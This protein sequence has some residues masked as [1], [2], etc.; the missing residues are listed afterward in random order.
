MLPR[1]GSIVK[2]IFDL[3][4]GRTQD[5]NLCTAKIGG[6]HGVKSTCNGNL[7]ALL[8]KMATITF[9][10]GNAKKLGEVNAIMA[11]GNPVLCS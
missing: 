9:V 4:V 2:M 7:M 10:T 6:G 11:S 8:A 1:D 5:D 3:R